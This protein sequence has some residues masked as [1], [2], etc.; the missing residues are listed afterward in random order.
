VWIDLR[1]FA[2]SSHD[3][4]TAEGL[5]AYIAGE[6]HISTGQLVTQLIQPGGLIFML[7]GLQDALEAAVAFLERFEHT[8]NQFLL[9]SQPYVDLAGL[10]ASSL[11]EITEITLGPWTLDQMDDFCG[12]WYAELECKEWVDVEAARDLPGDLRSA[13][14]RDE[15][16]ALA[17]RPSLMTLI[18]LLHTVEGDLP[19]NRVKLYHQLIELGFTV[20]SEGRN[21]QERDLRQAFDLEALRTAV[22]EATYHRLAR[23]ER[24]A[25]LVEFSASDLRALLIHVCR[26]GRF[27]GVDTLVT[28]M[29]TR[30]SLL[31]ECAPDTY[32]YAHPSLQVHAAAGHLAIQPELPSL[33]VSLAEQNLRWHE[34]ILLAGSRLAQAE[35]DGPSDS[36]D[37]RDSRDS[38]ALALVE[39]LCPHAPPT[40]NQQVSDTD[41]RLARL[42]GE[43]LIE[44]SQTGAEHDLARMP[45]LAQT[46]GPDTDDRQKPGIL[47][48][49]KG[50][51]AATVEQ[52]MLA[53]PER[54]QAGSV[55]DRLPNGDPRPGVSEP[56]PIWC[57]VPAGS[58]W[59]GDDQA[60]QT[61]QVDSFWISRYPTTN[62]Q[63]AAFVQA[64]GH[65][66]PGHWQGNHPPAG[67]RN[68]PV[69]CITWQDANDYC[70]WCTKHFSPGR[71]QV[72]QEDQVVERARVT[73]KVGPNRVIRLPTSI[74]WEKAARG[75]FQIPAPANGSSTDDAFID[76]P[77]PRRVY[78]WGD[79]WQLSSPDV[80]GDETRC[81]VSESC[82]GTTTPVGMYPGSVSPYGLMDMAGN[83]WEWCLDWADEDHRYKIRR[84]GAFRYTHER[85]RC[86]AYDQAHPSLG[87]P[88]LGFRIVLAPA[89][90]PTA[91]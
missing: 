24:E 59:Q 80:E 70:S 6:L 53:P 91:R 84:G 82:I 66:P 10:P 69:V 5:C 8:P 86:A 89:K 51:L 2:D 79:G 85:A 41:W 1:A 27:E 56:E 44:I 47:G 87:W 62:A 42:A 43:L 25:G 35:T 20:W 63:Y 76:N 54:A 60:A 90:R 15:V 49:V 31:E 57:P 55:L 28:R 17:Q 14:R 30:P 72:W 39:A 81:N 38:P 50:W 64:T 67:T 12:R 45:G 11:Q 40:V 13:L 52:G 4:S 65:S 9:T 16:I 21:E 29:L 26:D 34:V 75:G 88:H 77:L 37:S 46:P 7:D 68:H 73:S 3:T 48:R 71:T 19:D 32:V 33:V 74:E 36:R 23:L 83:V 58:F 78:P 61:V 22:A 18:A